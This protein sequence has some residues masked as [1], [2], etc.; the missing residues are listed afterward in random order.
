[1]VNEL[2]RRVRQLEDRTRRYSS[3]ALTVEEI[4]QATARYDAA[5]GGRDTHT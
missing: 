5:G 2:R 4:D 1:M 3:P